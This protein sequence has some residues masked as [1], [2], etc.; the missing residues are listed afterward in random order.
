[1]SLILEALRRAD[2]ERRLERAPDLKAVYEEDQVQRESGLRSLFWLCG[3]FL[4]GAVIVGLIL[5]PGLPDPSRP[6]PSSGN[7]GQEVVSMPGPKTAG[8]GRPKPQYPVKEEGLNRNRSSGAAGERPAYSDPS[9]SPGQVRPA[10]GVTERKDPAEKAAKTVEPTPD[11]R[12]VPGKTPVTGP[13]PSA[14]EKKTTP[15]QPQTPVGSGSEKAFTGLSDSALG[16]RV[17]GPAEKS[18]KSPAP[19]PPPA[20]RGERVARGKAGDLPLIQDLPSEVREKLGKLEINVHSYSKNPAERLVF[21]NMRSYREGDRI[22]ADGPVLK[23]ITSD[24]VIID[25][26]GGKARIVVWR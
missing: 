11:S 9:R 5:W 16:R 22:G 13:A 14:T 6:P 1:M 12:P 26:G 23:E 8:T 2:R 15:P 19:P 24:G 20:E 4:V 21:I 17:Q 3:A 7:H 18:A 25:Y 10:E